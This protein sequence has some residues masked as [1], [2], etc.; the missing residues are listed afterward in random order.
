MP[1]VYGVSTNGLIKVHVPHPA[2]LAG[3]SDPDCRL[4]APNENIP[5]D[6]LIKGIKFAATI[7]DMYGRAV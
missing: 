4:H 1:T 2:V 3:F 5:V 6:R 7:M